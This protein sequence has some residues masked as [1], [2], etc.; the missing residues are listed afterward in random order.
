MNIIKRVFSV[1]SMVKSEYLRGDLPK[2]KDAY[3][4]LLKIAVP[5]IVEMVFVSLISSVDIIMVSRLGFEAIAAVGLA[6]QPNMIMLSMFLALNVGVTAIVARRKGENLPDAANLTLRN[7]LML[8]L[9]FSFVVMALTLIF[10]RRL[11]LVAGA[12]P[13]TI[14]MADDYFRIIVYFLPVNA[15]TMC[16][17]AAQRGVGNTRITMISNIAANVV[18]V[19]FDY[20]LIYG[21]LGFPKLG[22]A[23]D[24]WASG[25]GFCVALI[26]SS[27]ALF[28]R[29]SENFF[30]HISLKD[31]WR[32]NKNTVKSIL[33][34][35]GNSVIEQIG[36]RIGFFI[37]AVVVANL[38]TAVFAA[39]QVA[40]Q[41]LGFSFNFGNG[42]A[43]AGTSLVGQMLGQKRP[44]LAAVYG[45]CAQRLSLVMSLAL[46]SCIV[47]FRSPLVSIFLAKS[48]PANAVPFAVALELM[49]VV[50]VF[51]PP[52]TSSVVVSGCLRGAGD[53]FYVAIVMIICVT[54]IRPV[55]SV[56][57]VY[58][59]H[60]G[61][62]GAWC[63][64]LIDMC[65]R[66]GLVYYRFS[67]SK[68][69]Y[70]KV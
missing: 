31:D 3:S 49:L 5:S 45:K 24:A 57:A 13:D 28:R 34:V 6:G 38:G 37:Y 7:A 15:L 9:G 50:A 61:I 4:E 48:D 44:D 54:F 23:G 63:A 25:I 10:S 52:Q 69:H 47:A 32:L 53:N 36:Q 1:N 41:F 27:A 19:F 65:I 46:A 55:F 67:G 59:F 33:K 43:V 42:L 2:S 39:H 14:G 68:W 29:T 18:N 12:Q 35:G 70:K 56:L 66:L 58:V 8:I 51:Q 30:L 20:C 62:I 22:V 21:N 11:M 60:F 17:N 26:L 16:I 64:A 40:M